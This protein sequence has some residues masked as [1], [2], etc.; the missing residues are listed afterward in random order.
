LCAEDRVDFGPVFDAELDT[1]IPHVD[2]SKKRRAARGRR[3]G[4]FGLGGGVRHGAGPVATATAAPAV[5]ASKETA[6]ARA[7]TGLT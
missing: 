2:N 1:V 7:D 5:T 3:G 6:I 4:Y